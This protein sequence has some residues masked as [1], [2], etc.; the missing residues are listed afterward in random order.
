VAG[1]LPFRLLR[2][3]HSRAH[4]PRTLRPPALTEDLLQ[5]R[6]AALTSLAEAGGPGAA[7]AR[8]RMQA[9]A[10][11]SDM[12]AFK[13]ANLHQGGGELGD[14]VRW[15]SP[16]DWVAEDGA[17]AANP[18]RLSA[19]ALGALAAAAPPRGQLSARMSTPG[20]LWAALWSEAAAIAAAEQKP[21][22]DATAAG[23]GVLHWLETLAPADMFAGLLAGAA[24]AT[25]ALL[26]AAPGAAASPGARAVQA[27]AAATAAAVLARACPF[28]EEW[29]A[30]CDAAAQA[31]ATA[32]AAE[33][34]ARRL[35][36]APAAAEAL[37]AHALT[38]TAM[39]DVPLD[40]VREREALIGAA[41]AGGA[42]PVAREFVVAAGTP[43]AAPGTVL[44]HRLHAAVAP[45][46]VAV[47]TAVSAPDV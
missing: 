13:A 42:E 25:L 11:L 43:G 41:L 16:R 18:A 14:F 28:P 2:W 4:A 35:P 12:C 23:E 24:S 36:Q 37:L 27:R 34:L 7:A 15:H 3:P 8:Q 22:Q 30:L 17:E 6:E 38:G 5:E 1:P 20:N 39:P 26:A 10:L 29:G 31:E 21:L 33:W 45:G 47:A 9:D 44:R 40:D 32:A 19:G 46:R